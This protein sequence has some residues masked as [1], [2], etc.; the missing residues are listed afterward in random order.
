M[1]KKRP[2]VW[3]FHRASH[4]LQGQLSKW[5][6]WVAH[7]VKSENLLN[8]EISFLSNIVKFPVVPTK[9]KAFI[10]G[11]TELT[12]EASYPPTGATWPVA[13]SRCGISK[14]TWAGAAWS[15]PRSSCHLAGAVPK[16]GRSFLE[17][18]FCKLWIQRTS[19]HGS[20]GSF[21]EGSWNGAHDLVSGKN[22]W[23]WWDWKKSDFAKYSG[24]FSPSAS[25]KNLCLIWSFKN[26]LGLQ[27]AWGLPLT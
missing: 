18:G 16:P 26:N 17:K 27:R 5:E 3:W 11:K 23:G 10:T 1:I 24:C 25:W 9:L 13:A 8:I 21:L 12:S 6:K 14:F 4:C 20:C 15:Q 19:L 22:T 7:K 2:F